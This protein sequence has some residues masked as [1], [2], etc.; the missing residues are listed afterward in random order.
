M[1][2]KIL[3]AA[4]Y[5]HHIVCTRNSPFYVTFNGYDNIA[6]ISNSES[7]ICQFGLTWDKINRV[8]LLSLPLCAQSAELLKKLAND[9]A[10][11]PHHQH[12]DIP[13]ANTL[14]IFTVPENPHI[15]YISVQ[16]LCGSQHILHI[17]VKKCT[18][19][20]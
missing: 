10:C 3:N 20:F 12:G 6:S 18:S 11:Q 8:D 7:K 16:S 17:F 19:K 14:S 9:S 1:P 13:N 5:I 4:S 15:K 2:I